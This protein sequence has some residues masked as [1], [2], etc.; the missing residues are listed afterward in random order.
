M[1]YHE[2]TLIDQKRPWRPVHIC[3]TCGETFRGADERFCPKCHEREHA[4]S[5]L[6]SGPDGGGEQ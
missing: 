5:P 2:S 1:G 6:G 4:G 3:P